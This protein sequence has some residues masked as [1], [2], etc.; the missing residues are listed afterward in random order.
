MATGPKGS[1][2]GKNYQR[3]PLTLATYLQ[4][5]SIGHNWSQFG[6]DR[7]AKPDYFRAIRSFRYVP[8]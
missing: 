7:T 5:P 4:K 6:I 2:Q 1:I 3:A 8:A